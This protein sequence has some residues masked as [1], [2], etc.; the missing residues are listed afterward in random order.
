MPIDSPYLAEAPRYERALHG[1][2]DAPEE[3]A[4]RI[5]VRLADPWVAVELAARTTP[6]PQY[7]ITQARGRVLVGPP[8]RIDAG[9]AAAMAG[10][11]GLTMT[12]GFTRRV[13]ELT[14]PRPGHGY[15]VDAAVEVARLARQVTWLP[16][17][18]TRAALAEGPRGAWRL[19]LQ[20]WA[21]LP[22]SCYAYRPESERLFAERPVTT[23]MTASLYSPSP[24]AVGVFTRTKAARLER[25]RR[26]LRLTHAMFDEVH[27]FQV[28]YRVDLETGTIVDAG[29]ITPRLPYGGICTDPQAR[30]RT[31]VG[32]PV[33]AGLRKRLGAL[34]GGPGGCAQLHDLT[35]DL[36][37]L[38]TLA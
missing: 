34:V 8:G 11:A 16:P 5:T 14:G 9:L 28:F 27:S 29:S 3:G 26:E 17:A 15:F 36:L 33:D 31:L 10:L 22:A 4:F 32:Q 38:L 13:A 1:W 7:A 24:G 12:A 20:G 37:K 30:V 21:D 23:A 6:S 2:V 25:E 35:A 18:V 19:D